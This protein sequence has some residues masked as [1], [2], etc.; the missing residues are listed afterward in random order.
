MKRRFRM[1][2]T[3]RT[4][5]MENRIAWEIFTK[6]Y[7]EEDTLR[8]LCTDLGIPIREEVIDETVADYIR[9]DKERQARFTLEAKID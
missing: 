5:S 1:Y 8:K 7:T 6:G 3:I 2:T 4:D 9:I